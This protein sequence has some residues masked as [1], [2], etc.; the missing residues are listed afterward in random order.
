MLFI[1]DNDINQA[2]SATHYLILVT[3]KLEHATDGI[4]TQ[5]LVDMGIDIDKY[6]EYGAHG[7]KAAFNDF[8]IR[9]DMR[10]ICTNKMF[11]QA[12]SLLEP[13]FLNNYVDMHEGNFMM[14]GNQLVINDPVL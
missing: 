3:E 8:F 13:L 2:K 10:N 9:K 7:I 14:R 5:N 4:I 11:K 6:V 12:I 1:C